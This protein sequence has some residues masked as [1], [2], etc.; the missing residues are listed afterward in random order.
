MTQ[1]FHTSRTTHLSTAHVAASNNTAITLSKDK[2]TQQCIQNVPKTHTFFPAYSAHKLP[3]L[4]LTTTPPHYQQTNQMQVRNNKQ[5]LWRPHLQLQTHQ[6]KTSSQY[7]SRR[8]GTSI[9]TCTSHHWI[10]SSNIKNRH[11]TKTTT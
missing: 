8:V 5:H 3:T 4:S 9:T 11:R 2:S 7:N 6:Q 1:S 10:H